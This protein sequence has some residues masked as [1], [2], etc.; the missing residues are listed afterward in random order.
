MMMRKLVI[1][2]AAA[3][4]VIMPLAANALGF[5]NI[6]LNSALDEPMD[7]NIELL[8]PTPDDIENLKVNLA[9]SATFMRAGVDRPILLE[10]LK[11]AVKQQN[12]G[13]YFIHITSRER[14]REP[15]L[16][17]LLEMEWQNGRMV[18]EYTVLL[19]PPGTPRKAPAVVE[20]P[21]TVAPQEVAKQ[22]QV[23][24]VVSPFAAA[25]APEPAAMPEPTP[26][27]VPVPV[28]TEP[29]E[30]EFVLAEGEQMPRIPLTE[31]L[32]PE[33]T[34]EPQV[35][36]AKPEPVPAPV[37]VEEAAA[38]V[39][40]PVP[41]EAVAPT[42]VAEPAGLPEPSV[43][44][45]AMADTFEEDTE[46]FPRIPLTAYGDTAPAEP[47]VLGELDYGIVQ[48]GDS[49]WRISEKIRPD[50]SISVY[51]VMMALLKSNPDAF[52]DGNVNR[53]KV[54][55]V[56]RIEDPGLL[57]AMSTQEAQQEFQSQT[58]VWE[59]YRQQ[60][61]ESTEAQP[62][63]AGEVV[64]E[65]AATA[66][67]SGEL[68]LAS[69]EGTELQAGAGTTEEVVNDNIVT[70]RDELRQ[71]R[72]DSLAMGSQNEEL[73]A[74]LQEMDDELARLQ[75][76]VSIEDDEL[77]A[78]Q[79]QLAALQAQAT[80]S[81][82]VEV[83]EVTETTVTETP[84]DVTVTETTES[85]VAAVEPEPVPEGMAEETPPPVM[86]EETRSPVEIAEEIAT[87]EQAAP[88]P[89]AVT[90]P[91]PEVQAES[92]GILGAVLGG[93]KSVGE[94]LQ[95]MF[96]SSL[97]MF[98]ALPALLVLIVIGMI[99]I[100]RR[101][102]SDKYQESIL[103]GGP[104]SVTGAQEAEE[105]E[106]ESSFLSDFAVSGA[107]AIQ[108]DESEVDPLTEADVFMA[109]GRYEAAEERLKEAIEND[110]GRKEL[111]LKLIELYHTTKDK[112]AFEKAAENFH[113]ALGDGANEDPLWQ[114]VVAM[115]S[116]LI[117][118][119]V[120]FSGAGAA[121]MAADMATG[122]DTGVGLSD[123]QVMDIGLDTGVFDAGEVATSAEAGGDLDFNL[124]LEQAEPAA[125]ESSGGVDFLDMGEAAAEP[126]AEAKETSGLDF[127]LDMGE[128]AAEPETES[129][130]SSGIDFNLDMAGAE[131]APVEEAGG[132]FEF[133][134]DVGE[135]PAAEA[136]PE[137]KLESEELSAMDFNVE[138]SD[139]PQPSGFT[140]LDEE[141]EAGPDLDVSMANISMADL[142]GESD[143]TSEMKMD[144]ETAASEPSSQTMAFDMDAAS[145]EPTE[146]EIS[147]GDEVGTKLDLAKAYIDMGDPDGARSILDEVMDE[148][149]DAQKE[150]AQ[151][152]LQQIA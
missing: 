3:V 144:F 54:G 93:V 61:A 107:G 66:E 24:P 40:V 74:R 147:M 47:Q 139:M 69:P 12:D 132:D 130:D 43:V 99:L 131:A 10:K 48:K 88:A 134:L 143:A 113:S 94:V 59:E 138:T 11:F 44:D 36:A 65:E 97:V 104:S 111:K 150:E 39:P 142:A 7:A 1:F 22:E 83:A 50:D 41:E 151:Q 31:S 56:L 26:V 86:E 128:T 27:P 117:P 121:A 126:E 38:P 125:T 15:F 149:N 110:P 78:L 14:V 101:S 89:V 98:V 124:D 103:T 32:E 127:S 108:G 28:L 120:L 105:A 95:G 102:K 148:G 71:I 8:S 58:A 62:I 84:E 91:E 51:Q 35:A 81:P 55:H 49:L 70:L 34:P 37:P 146:A 82:A 57:T 80:E 135:S 85:V 25:P 6:K 13:T 17:F 64:S 96:G 29:A 92:E 60:V 45:M 52:V 23:A 16:D 115:G 76:S 21:A 77:A 67:P 152:L 87:Q 30:G 5:G 79:Q 129:E 33:P 109:Y 18:R 20:V 90:E 53:L 118:G 2:L 75:R 133:N 63:V 137:P 73:N 116:D 114:K 19:D 68:T 123:S 42:P 136:E 9:S 106:E 72:E 122:G 112:P 100:R 4:L 145:E 119:N 141:A 46:L 140:S